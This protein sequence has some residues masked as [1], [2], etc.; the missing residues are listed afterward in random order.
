MAESQLRKGVLELIVLAALEKEPTYGGALIEHLGMEVSSGTLYPLLTR[1]KKHAWI[2][3]HWEE[4][5]SGP[6]R[7]IYSVTEK[8]SQRITELAQEWRA[9]SVFVNEHLEGIGK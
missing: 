3:S 6:P 1:M 9:L 2:G 8:G 7:K 4:S 5:P